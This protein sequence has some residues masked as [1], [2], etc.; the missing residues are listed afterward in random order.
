MIPPCD[1]GRI[2]ALG[3]KQAKSV[4]GVVYLA[5]G[6]PL[7]YVMLEIPASARY[8]PM[9]YGANTWPWGT[10]VCGVG[11]K[12]INAA[13]VIASNRVAAAYPTVNATASPGAGGNLQAQI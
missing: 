1:R 3:P 13:R 12:G 7:K 9:Q 4:H 5:M 8:F 2:S 6:G 10:E 11:I